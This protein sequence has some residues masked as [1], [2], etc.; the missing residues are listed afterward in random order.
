M[1]KAKQIELVG[2]IQER[3]DS[4]IN[5]ANELINIYEKT[6]QEAFPF[7][8]TTLVPSL[9][10]HIK[11]MHDYIFEI[12]KQEGLSDED[13]YKKCF[14]FAEELQT[15]FNKYSAENEKLVIDTDDLIEE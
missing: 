10:I 7:L 8:D 15:L 1:S 2:N 3:V 12:S 5:Y 14:K 9:N 11:T 6:H 13:S 4:S